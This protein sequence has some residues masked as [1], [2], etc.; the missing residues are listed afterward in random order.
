MQL[1]STITIKIT[2]K[3]MAISPECFV[4]FQW[5]LQN[6]KEQSFNLTNGTEGITQLLKSNF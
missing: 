1:R 5:D 2:V 4:C 6:W 3:K